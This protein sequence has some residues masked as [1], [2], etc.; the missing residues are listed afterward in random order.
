MPANYILLEKITV[1]AYTDLVVKLSS[2]QSTA[3]TQCLITV[4]GST[5]TY[6]GKRL[7]GSGSAAYSDSTNT[8]NFN[9]SAVNPSSYTASVFANAEFV[10]PNYTSSN[11]KSFSIDNVSENN[12]ATAYSGLFAGLWSQTAAITSFTIYGAT[13]DFV[14]YSTFYLYGVAALGTT[15]AIVHRMQQVAILL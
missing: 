5:S 8:N 7:Y 4:N 1:G 2:R 11:Y 3:S 9:P 6:T 12:A 14:Q 10:I 13:S 15:P